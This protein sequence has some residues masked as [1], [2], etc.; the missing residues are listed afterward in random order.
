MARTSL[1]GLRSHYNR[2]RPPRIFG[3]LLYV[4]VPRFTCIEIREERV[5]LPRRQGSIVGGTRNDK[6]RTQVGARCTSSLAIIHQE[7]DQILIWEARFV[8]FE[9][10]Y[11]YGVSIRALRIHR[12]EFHFSISAPFLCAVALSPEGHPVVRPICCPVLI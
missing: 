8:S 9:P 2:R 12:Q 11:D 10:A 6:L 7:P 1:P 4:N 3:E 5:N